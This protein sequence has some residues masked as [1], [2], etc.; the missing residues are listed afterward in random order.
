MPSAPL[1][2]GPLDTR[3][4]VSYDFW[5]AS[6]GFL[7]PLVI[8][9]FRWHEMSFFSRAGAGPAVQAIGFHALCAI[10][11][12]RSD[13]PHLR[14]PFGSL[15][16]CPFVRSYLFVIYFGVESEPSHGGC[17]ELW[18]TFGAEVS[19]AAHEWVAHGVL[20]H[21]RCCFFQIVFSGIIG[22][23]G[24]SPRSSY[25]AVLKACALLECC[26][27]PHMPF[28]T[29]AMTSSW[30]GSQKPVEDCAPLWP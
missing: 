21:L 23:F 28:M 22:V 4:L 18:G 16:F 19:G 2:R 14:L 27:S 11:R 12:S 20:P 6:L 8:L 30:S 5:I 24:S 1:G 17:Y 26:S 9:G 13:L 10:G 29:Q 7:G 3:H 25:K 15:S